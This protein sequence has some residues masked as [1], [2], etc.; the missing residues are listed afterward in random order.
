M[1]WDA[2]VTTGAYFIYQTDGNAVVYASTG[3]AVWVSHTS[4][5]GLPLCLTSDGH[6]VQYKANGAAA[7]SVPQLQS[8]QL[9]TKT[10]TTTT[11]SS[12]SAKTFTTSSTTSTTTTST[13]SSTSMSS[14]TVKTTST[15][16]T[17]STTTKT[18]STT[19]S[20]TK[21]STTTSTTSS[22]TRTT[23]T[24]TCTTSTTSTKTTS[25]TSTKSI[26]TSTSDLVAPGPAV[27]TINQQAAL[28]EHNAYR[29]AHGIPP[30]TYNLTTEV[31]ASEYAVQLAS[32]GCGL[33]HGDHAGLGQNLA[34]YAE[35]GGSLQDMVFLIQL[36]EE[37]PVAP[38]A[39][40]YNHATQMLWESTMN[41]GCSIAQGMNGQWT[42]QVL[43]CDY[44]PPGNWVGRTWQS[45]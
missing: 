12:T 10:I 8:A 28:N 33:V 15:T 21:T 26:T 4:G 40:L 19:S 31:K 45:G 41:L 22:T 37:E 2:Q 39:G 27:L 36:W 1:L 14:S 18:T 13:T 11:T 34:M 9:S 44:Y 43:V 29:A 32:N 3:K 6:L 30:L 38:S 24:K 17:T 5:Q 16:S 20:S 42:C 7:W 23:S 25:T 35:M